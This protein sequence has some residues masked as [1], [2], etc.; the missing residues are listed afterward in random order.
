MARRALP[1]GNERLVKAVGACART[2]ALDE[3]RRPTGKPCV[4]QVAPA[5]RRV[6]A[7]AGGVDAS[8]TK[9]KLMR[10]K[11]VSALRGFLVHGF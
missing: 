6:V 5:G 4:L 3:L 7:Q 1:H 2:A 10:L 11:K 8:W 9:A